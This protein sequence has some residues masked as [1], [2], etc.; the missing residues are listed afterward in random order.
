MDLR[1]AS[2]ATLLALALATGA[3]AD[4]TVTIPV[5]DNVANEA[6]NLTL[7]ITVP[8]EL[9]R[10]E[11]PP[12]EREIKKKR[13]HYRKYFDLNPFPAAVRPGDLEVVGRFGKKSVKTTLVRQSLR[14]RGSA[15][16]YEIA[17]DIAAVVEETLSQ[18]VDELATRG[19]TRGD[20]NEFITVFDNYPQQLK[21]MGVGKKHREELVKVARKLAFTD[22]EVKVVKVETNDV[23]AT[24]IQLTLAGTGEKMKPDYVTKLETGRLDSMKVPQEKLEFGT[25]NADSLDFEAP[26]P[27][28]GSGGAGN[29]LELPPD[30]L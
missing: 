22:G 3:A 24:V 28:K 15:S 20:V 1:K 30:D 17:R 9:E 26:P 12:R 29:P 13:T 11:K 18:T 19:V 8:T 14:T 27:K 21:I 16:A 5:P 4:T 6:K 23:G 2:T 25:G 7:T 10:V